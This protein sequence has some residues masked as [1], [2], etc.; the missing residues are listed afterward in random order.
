MPSSLSTGAGCCAPS[1][2]P[3]QGHYATCCGSSRIVPV[4]L[5]CNRARAARPPRSLHRS[6]ATA[7]L[8]IVSRSFD[9]PV[10]CRRSDGW[11]AR[12]A[13]L[14]NGTGYGSLRS[15]VSHTIGGPCCAVRRP[16][17]PSRLRA[18]QRLAG[19]PHTEAWAHGSFCR[20][21]GATRR[22]AIAQTARGPVRKP[23]MRPDPAL[24]SKR[25]IAVPSRLQPG[26]CSCSA[27]PGRRPKTPALSGAP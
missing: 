9:E 20:R 27:L 5:G 22:P 4:R 2:L 13:L 12:G 11:K 17:T 3:T 23:R 24:E 14:P 15:L 26:T 19:M 25:L 7:K 16:P 6:R 8:V 10:G 18:A 21:H 1:S